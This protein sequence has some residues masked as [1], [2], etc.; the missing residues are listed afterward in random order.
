VF[1]P[2][3]RLLM[4]VGR[5]VPLLRRVAAF[6]RRRAHR[7]A[8]RYGTAGGPLALVL[9]SFTV[10][11]MTG[12]AATVVAGHGFIPGWAIAITG[13]MFYFA[14]LMVSTLWLNELFG[15]QRLVVGVMLFVMFVLPSL[16]RRVGG[17]ATAPTPT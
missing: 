12:R 3:L 6:L 17:A 11:P 8:A 1:E 10:D 9:V 14:L 5:A 4:L 7:A 16:I 13:D 15:D 2:I